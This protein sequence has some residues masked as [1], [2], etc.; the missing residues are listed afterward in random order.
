M[1]D[2][3]IDYRVDRRARF[4]KFPVKGEKKKKERMFAVYVKG[5]AILTQSNYRPR[6]LMFNTYINQFPKERTQR[7][8]Q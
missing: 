1:F 6:L 5:V 7:G 2:T 3:S 8:G 4:L